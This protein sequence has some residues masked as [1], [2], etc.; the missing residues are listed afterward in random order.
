MLKSTRR[1]MI[2]HAFARKGNLSSLDRE[3]VD[4]P[5]AAAN[6]VMLALGIPH[7]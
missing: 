1:G 2:P 5:S 3:V 6:Q 7:R 4:G